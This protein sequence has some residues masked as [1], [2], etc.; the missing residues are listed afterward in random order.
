MILAGLARHGKVKFEHGPLAFFAPDIDVALVV[1]D[2]TPH[3]GHTETGA[4]APQ[5]LFGVEGLENAG[6]V[7]FGNAVPAVRHPQEN[8][9]PLGDF[10]VT[11]QGLVHITAFGG[12]TD[13]AAAR[14]GFGG[15]GNQIQ[16]RLF[17]MDR[18]AFHVGQIRL[19]DN[20][21]VHIR[22][23]ADQL[24]VLRRTD[25]VGDDIV[26]I[27]DF[28]GGNPPAGQGQK[29]L[30][31]GGGLE[32]GF[33]DRHH[34]G[35]QGAVHR[36]IHQN[37]IGIADDAREDIVEIMGHASRQKAEGLH[38]PGSGQLF[39]EFETFGFGLFALGGVAR[40]P[41]NRIRTSLLI[42]H[43]R[44]GYFGPDPVAV[45]VVQ[46]QL[47]GPRTPAISPSLP[48]G[49]HLGKGRLNPGT[50]GFGNDLLDVEGQDFIGAPSQG[51][52]ARG[53]YIRKVIRQVHG[54]DGFGNA[55]GEQTIFLFA[56]PQGLLGLLPLGDVAHDAHS[57]PLLLETDGRQ[58][59]LHR[60]FVPVPMA[61]RQFDGA[62]DRIP[63]A[64]KLEGFK[65]LLETF[66]IPIR[67][68][69]AV[70]PSAQHVLL[71]IAEHLLP[72]TAP[73]GD[74]PFVVDHDDGIPGCIADGP[75]HLLAVL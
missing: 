12:N 27:D 45:F 73:V 35:R 4:A 2:R 50:L 30:H 33:L 66:Q 71:P 63:F 59:K 39:K 43:D 15:I 54:P 65:G 41:Q 75:E 21:E 17:K 11:G 26:E 67:C 3:H 53:T 13:Q 70:Q 29:V 62:A 1:L 24:L 61:C 19:A 48:V 10:F 16:N 8:I 9:F 32:A 22:M 57:M 23:E 6:Q 68:Q 25:D 20:L 55:L 28:K 58:G 38:L 64:G 74:F 72:G 46:F 40:D 42:H 49:D 52:P 47:Q 44:G 7:F 36:K 34:R 37:Q 14:L 5:N 69:K 60:N 31:D 51:M 18:R 56:L